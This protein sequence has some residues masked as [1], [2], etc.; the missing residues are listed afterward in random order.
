MSL[1]S[2][3]SS[4][5]EL[6]SETK[7]VL[8]AEVGDDQEDKWLEVFSIFVH[9]IESPLASIK[10]LLRIMEDG[11]L[12]LS[13]PLHQR[14]IKSSRIALERAESIIF[15]IM[16]VA[17]AGSA[18]LPVSNAVIDPLPLIKESVELV[19]ASAEDRDIEIKLS[20][21]EQQLKVSADPKLL[22]RVLDNL[23]YNSLRHTPSGRTI[24]VYLEDCGDRLFVHIKDDGS[25][26]GEIDPSKLFEKYGQLQLRSEGKHRGVGLGLYFCKLAMTGMGGT[27]IAADHEDGGA[28]FSIRLKKAEE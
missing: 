19:S 22:P 13:K 17:R 27:V 4:M 23:L 7:N 14:M 16:A 28:V 5:S 15:D 11:R 20:V 25:G 24:A 21:P 1:K 26:L 18:G 8:T 9:D 6:G 10:Y 3:D 12:D 2:A